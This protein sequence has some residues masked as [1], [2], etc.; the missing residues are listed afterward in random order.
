MDNTSED[1]IS[2]KGLGFPAAAEMISRLQQQIMQLFGEDHEH[3]DL[4]DQDISSS[5]SCTT[6]DQDHDQSANN[7]DKRMKR[8]PSVCD[9]ED[10]SKNKNKNKKRRFRSI[11]SLYISTRPIECECGSVLLRF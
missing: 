6:A 3:E 5:S 4:Q 10:D 8:R 7:K 1:L 11:H 9:Q 2:N